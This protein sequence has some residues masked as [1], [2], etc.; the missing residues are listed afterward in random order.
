MTLELKISSAEGTASSGAFISPVLCVL[1]APR[2]RPVSCCV[3]LQTP[4][5]AGFTRRAELELNSFS[6]S[7][8]AAEA[9]VP[10]A[11]PL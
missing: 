9:L 2:W 6:L 10:S 1:R 7:L 4:V 5:S 3:P 11:A 8:P